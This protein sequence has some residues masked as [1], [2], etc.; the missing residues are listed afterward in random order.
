MHGEEDP[1]CD[2][3]GSLGRDECA[4]VEIADESEGQRERRIEQRPDYE[5]AE[6]RARLSVRSPSRVRCCEEEAPR[7]WTRD[8]GKEQPDGAGVFGD[9]GV[10]TRALRD[11]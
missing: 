5:D 9:R 11:V 10:R 7:Q 4:T 3:E 1:T 6:E 2:A 8:D